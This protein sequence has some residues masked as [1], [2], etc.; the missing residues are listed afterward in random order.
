MNQN[1]NDIFNGEFSRRYDAG[2]A[3]FNTIS[4]NLHFLIA[5]LLKDLPVNAHILCVGVGTGTEMIHLARQNPSWR[6]TGVDPSADMLAVCAA[7]LRQAKISERCT[8][9]EG[10][11]QDL[12]SAPDYDAVLCLLVTHFILDDARG[13][14]YRHMASRLNTAGQ[15][16]IAEISGDTTAAD[17]DQHL[18]SWA[19]M[20]SL[21]GQTPRTPVELRAQL[22]QRLLLLPPK[23]TERL[24]AEAGFSPP[25]RFFQSLLI[26]AWTARKPAIKNPA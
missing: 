19:A 4:D 15:V 7:K 17:F 12:P 6:F 26:H 9:V 25:Q 10:Y 22:Q 24:I 20:Q 18:A 1:T 3:R 23:H 21:D 11:L 5:L 13:G 2:N 8:L 16:V 14:L